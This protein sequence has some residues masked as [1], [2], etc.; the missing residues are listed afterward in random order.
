M[1]LSLEM[2]FKLG[3]FPMNECL[4]LI[5]TLD[6]EITNAAPFDGVTHDHDV[7]CDHVPN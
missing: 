3:Q 5:Y 7:R 4:W 1:V 2:G 6:S